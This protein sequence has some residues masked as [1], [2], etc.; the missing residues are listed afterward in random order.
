MV[1]VSLPIASH[2]QPQASTYFCSAQAEATQSHNKRNLLCETFYTLHIFFLHPKRR[3]KAKLKRIK[4][5]SPNANAPSVAKWKTVKV[6]WNR[7]KYA[8][9]T[10]IS[11][12]FVF[13]VYSP[14]LIQI[15]K[16]K[17]PKLK[18]PKRKMLSRQPLKCRTLQFE[19]F[20]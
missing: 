1:G 3:R 19:L 20:K 11:C 8:G 14:L 13:I 16:T 2:P 18:F 9:A 10:I 15:Y 4:L 17:I 5:A 7:A 6:K 12:A